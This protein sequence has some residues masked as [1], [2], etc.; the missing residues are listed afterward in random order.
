MTTLSYSKKKTVKKAANIDLAI[1]ILGVKTK[2]E[3]F[4]KKSA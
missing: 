1:Y 3:K 2:K 4:I